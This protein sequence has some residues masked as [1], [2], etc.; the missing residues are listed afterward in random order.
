[1]KKPIILISA[2]LLILSL[3]ACGTPQRTAMIDRNLT[4]LDITEWKHTDYVTQFTPGHWLE[5]AEHLDGGMLY[6]SIAHTLA[7]YIRTYPDGYVSQYGVDFWTVYGDFCTLMWNASQ[8]ND[9]TSLQPK[10]REAASWMIE[11]DDGNPFLSIMKRFSECETVEGTYPSFTDIHTEGTFIVDI[12]DLTAT[13][14]E[15]GITET[16]LGYTL[17]KLHDYI[18][19]DGEGFDISFDEN[20]FHMERPG[21]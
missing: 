5:K 21:E 13:A 10:F 11:D 9:D 6:D 4:K 7:D 2:A 8:T 19:E 16:A 18:A 3:C 12:P 15:L 1:M 17:G 20:S 14:K